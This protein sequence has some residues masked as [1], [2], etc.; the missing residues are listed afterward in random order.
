MRCDQAGCIYRA[1]GHTVALIMHPAA[2][3]ED[4]W[5]ADVIV[6][7]VPL[8]GTNCPA[9]QTIIDRFDIWRNGAYALWLDEGRVR[10]ENV[11]QH[12]GERPWAPPK[13]PRRPR[14]R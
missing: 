7:V 4:C 1:R 9:P 6:S 12:Q 5:V 2:F 13:K 3:L 8:R 10:V 14:A 11:R